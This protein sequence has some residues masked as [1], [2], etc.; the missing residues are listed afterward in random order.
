MS[1]RC[2]CLTCR[3]FVQSL[4][5]PLTSVQTFNTP[6]ADLDPDSAHIVVLR[7]PPKTLWSFKVELSEVQ[8][9]FWSHGRSRR[10][11]DRYLVER[12]GSK[13]FR[14]LHPEERFE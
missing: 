8:L 11:S 14:L 5:F 1:Q 2:D 10:S 6:S 4:D 12:K 7:T 13:R 3:D 9:V